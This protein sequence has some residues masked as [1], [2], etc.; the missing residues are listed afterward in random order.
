ML[1]HFEQNLDRV[2]GGPGIHVW[3][4]GYL[5]TSHGLCQ[6]MGMAIHSIDTKVSNWFIYLEVIGASRVISVGSV[7]ILKNPVL[8]QSK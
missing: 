1:K 2:T 6:V 5:W 4:S 3:N 8:I 7:E